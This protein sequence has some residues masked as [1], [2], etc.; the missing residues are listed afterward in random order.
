MAGSIRLRAGLLAG[1]PPLADREP[2]YVRD[3]RALYIGTPEGN[4]RLTA[5][6]A[7]AVSA[8]AADADTAAVIAA[9]NALLSALQAAGLMETEGKR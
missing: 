4:V 6:P 1:M 2:A 3:Q 5:P 9:Y 7:A 8:L